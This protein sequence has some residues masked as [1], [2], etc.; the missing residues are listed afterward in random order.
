MQVS[1]GNNGL[2]PAPSPLPLSTEAMAVV[3]FPN[4]YTLGTQAAFTTPPRT[5]LGLLAGQLG[6]ALVRQRTSP[7]SSNH[8]QALT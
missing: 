6:L 7:V 5:L 2:R 1:T 8:F 4:G 3:T